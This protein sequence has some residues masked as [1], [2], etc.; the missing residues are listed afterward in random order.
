[1]LLT[2]CFKII[3]ICESILI[4]LK[5]VVLCYVQHRKLCVLFVCSTIWKLICDWIAIGTMHKHTHTHSE[6]PKAPKEH[7]TWTNRTDFWH[8]CITQFCRLQFAFLLT[9]FNRARTHTRQICTFRFTWSFRNNESEKNVRKRV[10]SGKMSLAIVHACR[11]I[12]RQNQMKNEII[13]LPCE[14]DLNQRQTS[15]T[16]FSSGVCGAH[17]IGDSLDLEIFNTLD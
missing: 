17:K 10:T 2:K 11:V 5:I 1:M 9:H 13:F 4:R 12:Q 16:I 7:N 14:K 15:E 6:F 3:I 8:R